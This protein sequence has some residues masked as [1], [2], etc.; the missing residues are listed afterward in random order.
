MQTWGI[1]ETSRKGTPPAQSPSAATKQCAQCKT[2]LD[3]YQSSSIKA[4]I[5]RDIRNE[6]KKIGKDEQELS[7]LVGADSVLKKKREIMTG[8]IGVGS[9]TSLAL[10]LQLPELGTTDRKKI[11]SLAGLAPMHRKSGTVNG[12]RSVK[13]GGREAIRTAL[14]MASLSAIRHNPDIR[15]Y[16]FGLKNRGKKGRVIFIAV[17]RKMLLHLHGLLKNEF[18]Q[19]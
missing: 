9:K 6:E 3:S 18:S 7:N 10:L 12:K 11:V 15:A 16:Y 5:R 1:Q 4:G 13:G 8:V 17:A 19:I 14:Y 2:S